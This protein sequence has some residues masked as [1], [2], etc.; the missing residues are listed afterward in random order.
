SYSTEALAASRF[1]AA[2]T[3]PGVAVSLRSTLRAQLA[4]V[5]PLTG[6]WTVS[7]VILIGCDRLDAGCFAGANHIGI[8]FHQ[9]TEVRD[10]PLGAGRKGRP[11]RPR[12]HAQ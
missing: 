7:I 3:T 6:K 8:H 1:T 4:Q 5:M 10:V 11:H 9:G 2:L 12:G